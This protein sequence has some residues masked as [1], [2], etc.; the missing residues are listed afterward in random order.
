[1]V[2]RVSREGEPDR[3]LK[4]L[5]RLSQTTR[6]RLEAEIK[7]LEMAKHI[8]GIV[9]LLEHEIPHNADRGPQW[10]VM[11]LAEPLAS[12]FR[13]QSAIDIV[14][15]FV[16]LAR[17]LAELHE[18][19][20]HHRDIKPANLLT[21]N[22][23]LC[24]SDFGLVKYPKRMDI[25][26]AQ[27]DVGPKF[28]MAPEMRR[29]A[30]KAAGGPADVY[31]LAKTLWIVL[32]GQPMGFDG[33]YSPI[34]VLALSKYH[35]EILTSPLDELLAECTDNDPRARPSATELASRLEDWIKLQ[36]DFHRRNLTEWMVIQNQLFPFC[37][38]SRATWTDIKDICA[39]L[40]L[41]SQ[42]RSL[43]HMF[44][45]DG[46]G[47]TINSIT[48]AAEAGFLRIHALSV[49]IVKPQKLTFE[50]FGP[51][52]AWNYFRLEAHS[53]A[54]LSVDGGY[55]D[56]EKGLEIFCELT[57]GQY[58]SLRAWDDDEYAGEPLPAGARPVT[59]YLSGSFVIFST[60]SPYNLD[61]TTYDARH[62]RISE[63][64]FRHYI[65][66]HIVT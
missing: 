12:A 26:P 65:A 38:P 34:S 21:L 4:I 6:S 3:A 20:I 41:A 50:S 29:D 46:G 43:N 61:P 9:P 53:V 16:A 66:S 31:S 24:F 33:Q 17:T 1:M 13:S 32:T 7:A 35:G 60:R 59:R 49:A 14:S 15:P 44:Y 57:P 56:L 48:F 36:E 19:G 25:T 8:D 47:N 55:I 39:V 51:A 22:G 11:P 23:R 40:R 5:R 28:T 52:S 37:S 2:W 63:D 45:P 64:D 42:T 54:P 18:L 62:N 10:F 27:G 30:A 58:V